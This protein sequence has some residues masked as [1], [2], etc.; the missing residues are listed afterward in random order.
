MGLPVRHTNE[1]ALLYEEF[2][3]TDSAPQLCVKRIWRHVIYLVPR[4]LVAW[5][6][7]IEVLPFCIFNLSRR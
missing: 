5:P 2:H 4:F 3:D 6:Q 7:Y 1:N